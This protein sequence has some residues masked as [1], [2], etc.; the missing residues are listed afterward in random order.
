MKVKFF[1]YK[2]NQHICS[3]RKLTIGFFPFRRAF[4]LIELLVVIAIIAILA[5]ILMPVLNQARIRAQEAECLSNLKQ[6][7]TGGFMYAQDNA[8][9]MLPNAPLGP[10]GT[11][12]TTTWCGGVGEGWTSSPGN[13]NVAQYTGSI[14]GPY[15]TTQVKVY[16][17][18]A[19]TV[20]SDNGQRIRSYSMNSEMGDEYCTNLAIGDN[21]SVRYF[22]KFTDL[23][24]KFSASDAF[25]FCEE[26]ACSIDDGW[27]QMASS[28]SAASTWGYYPNV[29]SSYHGKVCG[30]SFAD[31]HVEAHKWQTGDLPGYV[32]Q[33]YYTKNLGTKAPKESLTATGGAGN[34]DWKWLVAHT[35]VPW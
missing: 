4:T 15:M 8:D 34:P 11:T 28:S 25:I 16:H 35:S 19:D 23:N 31:G 1:S 13:T 27:L 12:L 26:N 3:S 33:Y 29:P 5:A 18:P 30:F 32:T 17:D 24:G 22:L 20:L 10:L 9:F 6:L 7:E 21:P 2:N 14:L